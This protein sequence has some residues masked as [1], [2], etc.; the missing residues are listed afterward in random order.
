MMLGAGEGLKGC[1]TRTGEPA[2]ALDPLT[3]HPAF[4]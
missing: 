1:A 3:R 4:G 2:L